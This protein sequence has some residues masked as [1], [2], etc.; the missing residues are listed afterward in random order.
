MEAA[1]DGGGQSSVVW[2]DMH[3]TSTA[4]PKTIFVRKA[5]V[6]VLGKL[7]ANGRASASLRQG[8]RWQNSMGGRSQQHI[9]ARVGTEGSTAQKSDSREAHTPGWAN[10]LILVQVLGVFFFL[11][12]V[13]TEQSPET[14]R[15]VLPVVP[16]P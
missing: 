16:N 13:L 1:V 12:E 3:E 8:A 11:E 4:V 5:K 6:A 14:F 2:T 15:Y 9:G 7:A 10:T